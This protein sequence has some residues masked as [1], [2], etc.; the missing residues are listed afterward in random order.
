[1]RRPGWG[2]VLALA[3]AAS[4]GGTDKNTASKPKK[5]HL[6]LR[7]TPRM[8]LSPVTVHFTAEIVGGDE[9]EEW[10]CPEIEWE[11]DDGGRSVQAS[12]CPPFAA[13]SKIERRYTASH[14]YARAGNYQPKVT[15]R[16]NSQTLASTSGR[17]T[18]R[19]GVSDNEGNPQ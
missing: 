17:I 4:V 19:P 11:W 3:L 14:D 1:M 16:H 9:L 7:L 6:E 18:V 13:D 2:M 12:D 5:P 15:L 10:Y 8:A